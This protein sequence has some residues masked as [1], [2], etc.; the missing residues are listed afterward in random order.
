MQLLHSLD[1]GKYYCKVSRVYISQ[2]TPEVESP[3]RT[4]VDA[5][6][7]SVLIF[8]VGKFSCGL[9]MSYGLELHA[10]PSLMKQS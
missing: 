2:S 10:W 3:R 9:G 6:D 1:I 7:R 5:S 8:T 4:F